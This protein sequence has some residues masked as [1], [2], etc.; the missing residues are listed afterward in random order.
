MSDLKLNLKFVPSTGTWVVYSPALDPPSTSAL[1]LPLLVLL[2]LLL[3]LLYLLLLLPL[4]LL[5][6]SWLPLRRH[7][8][9]ELL[10]LLLLLPY[11]LYRFLFLILLLP[12]FLYRS[13]LLYWRL[14]IPPSLI[15][16]LILLLGSLPPPFSLQIPLAVS[17]LLLLLYCNGSDPLLC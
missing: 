4:L 17:L 11:F 5:P 14:L 12:Y 16:L 2:P 3:L 10:F 6:S 8:Q 15:F 1:P 9:L 7:T 13:L